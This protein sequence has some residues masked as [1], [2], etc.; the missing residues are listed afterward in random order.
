LH[1]FQWF[2]R[3]WVHAKQGPM[4]VNLDMTLHFYPL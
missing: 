3:A 4:F 2:V 1:R